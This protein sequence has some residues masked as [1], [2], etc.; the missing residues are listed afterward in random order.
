MLPGIR[1]HEELDCVALLREFERLLG[2]ELDW[3]L[4]AGFN[5]ISTKSLGDSNDKAV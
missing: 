3:M 1:S 2:F 5:E 4:S